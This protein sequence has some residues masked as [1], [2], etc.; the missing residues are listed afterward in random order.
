MRDAFSGLYRSLSIVNGVGRPCRFVCVAVMVSRWVSRRP[1]DPRWHITSGPTRK[2]S[3]KIRRENHSGARARLPLAPHDQRHR[4]A[5]IRALVLGAAGHED[6]GM[7]DEAAERAGDESAG[8]AGGGDVGIIEHGMAIA[9]QVAAAAGLG[10]GEE[11][12]QFFA[13][14][15]G[16]LSR[17]SK[18][19]AGE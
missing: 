17:S 1:N 13:P 6:F 11:R 7:T 10:L 5:A 18:P 2:T 19:E 14:S 16:Q 12:D 15:L 4:P 8:V 9:A 3:A